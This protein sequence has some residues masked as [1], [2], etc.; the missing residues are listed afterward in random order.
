MQ[1]SKLSQLITAINDVLEAKDY[2]LALRILLGNFDRIDDNSPLRE[3]VALILA[4]KGR[5][6]EAVELYQLVARHYANA[7]H[8]VRAI[9]AARQMLKLNPDTTVVLDHI[10]TLYNIRSPFLST[11]IEH[12]RFVEP[13][14]DFDLTGESCTVA[15]ADLMEEA[16]SRS[17]DKTGL[18]SQPGALPSVPLLTLLP[19]ESLRRVLDLLEYNVFD[20]TQRLLERGIR[21]DDLVWTVSD[22]LIV[23]GDEQV[24]YVEAGS[25]LGLNGFGVAGRTSE[26]DVFA[27]SGAEILRLSGESIRRLTEEFGDFDNRLATLR[28]HAMTERLIRRHPMFEG[29]SDTER[30]RIMDQFTGL[31]LSGGDILI[32]QDVPTPGLF[33]ILDGVV[34]VVHTIQG[35]TT[36]LATLRSGDVFGEIGL[37]A[38]SPATAECTMTEPGHVLHL[39]RQDFSELAARYPVIRNYARN[40]AESRISEVSADELVEAE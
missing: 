39:A 31:R 6:R 40:L 19:Q 3:K 12:I 7:G 21:N 38:D 37:V 25:L 16:F 5:K 13:I 35:E 11:D 36:K 27:R 24:M 14:R 4:E 30:V 26:V 34:D 2:D 23:R 22:D 29:L 9:A 17:L 33:V 20:R 10:A 28:R 15:D 18:M 8:P 1:P 32:N